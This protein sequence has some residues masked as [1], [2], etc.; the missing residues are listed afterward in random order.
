[1]SADTE[2][3]LF[4][5][6]GPVNT[7][8]GHQI[9]GPAFILDSLERL[10]RVGRDPRVVAHEHLHWLNQRFVEPGHYGRARELLADSGSVLL[11]GAPGSGRRATAQMLLH[12]LNPN[13]AELIRELPDADTGG[14]S[15]GPVLDAQVVDSG[16]RLLLDLSTSEETY[17]EVVLGQLPS[18]RAEVQERGAHLVVVLPR[19]REHHFGSE[20]G[21]SVVEIVRRE[22]KGVF[23]RYLRSDGIKNFTSAQL[24]V[25]ELPAQLDSEPMR[26]IAQLAGLVRYAR[27]REPDQ[28]F[29]D[30]L[31]TARAALT[32]RSG[33]VAKQVKDLRSGQQRALLLTTA[34]FSGAHADAVFKATSTLCKVV[35][36]PEDDRPRL[37]REGV[38][39][40]LAEIEAKADDAGLVRFRLLAYDR[41]VRNHFW[42]NFPNLR[43][44]FR[45]WVGTAI[46]QRTLTAEDRNEVVTRFA[47]QA[48]RTGRPGDLL[49]L[50][51]R[52]VRRSDARGP[53]SLLPQ[54]AKALERGL[55]HE[56]YGV[57]FRRQLYTWSREPSLRHD[58]AQVVVQV[59]SEILALTHPEQAVVRL[60]HIVRRHSGSVGEAARD[61]LLGLVDRDR[62]LYRRLLD[63]VT[64]GPRAKDDEAADL[65][66]FLNLA[67]P[68]QLIDSQRRT[69]SLIADET[70][71]GQLITGWNA[72]LG[73]PS[74]LH[75]A[76]RHRVRTWLACEDGL[77]RELLLNV[78]V[79]AGDGRDDLLSRLYVIAR[80]WAYAPDDRREKRI[81]I[82][83]RL[84]NKINS[85]QGIDFTELDLGDR[86]EGTSP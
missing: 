69:R 28:K 11:T 10:V 1:M 36:H 8:T 59:C 35:Q 60:H 23:Q 77:Y 30:W 22:G 64:N 72:V 18:Y 70:V 73:G 38:A 24:D 61:A 7:G 55:S 86:T 78:L 45:D 81:G 44:G 34:M 9:N 31:S 33:E 17:C 13:N 40:Q 65:A 83:D 47:E 75:C 54:A 2:S 79:S 27:E 46:G 57:F 58:L 66:L 4:D 80:D 52:W 84:N 14:P 51:E 15:D 21:P 63:R 50:V 19:S 71:R 43:V 12:R 62:R 68:A 26:V 56:R 82:A 76:H 41:A 48:L 29:S 42:A 20:L 16:Q 39:E 5:S 3:F 6:H 32:E 25:D 53:S 85:A 49:S 67:D 37:E 74:S